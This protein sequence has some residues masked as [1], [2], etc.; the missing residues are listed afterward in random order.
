MP[1]TSP[2]TDAD[3]DQLEALL[4]DP[5]LDEAMRLDEI[6]GYLCG[7]FSGPSPIPA[8]QQLQEILGSDEAVASP[9]GQQLM[10]LLQRFAATQQAALDAGEAPLFLLYGEE[11]DAPEDY[12]AWCSAYLFAVDGSP[13]DWFEAIQAEEELDY[14]D[15]RLFPFM[16][17]TGEAEK[18]A[19][20][21]G[22]EWPSGEEKAELEQKAM[23]DLGEAVAEI[24]RFW[25]AK[26]G[27][28]TVR[29]DA[30][31]VGRNDPCPCGS[32]K[33]YK[34]CCGKLD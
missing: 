9:V 24:H 6:Q 31:K 15:E 19:L 5:S 2:L 7:A 34:Q 11:E 29:R 30:P 26:R 12:E 25:Q 22:E 17:L 14:L 13:E 8:E 18:A 10:P 23:D 21:H 4:D 20:E 27:G 1:T 32:G 33:K 16:I 28:E 3:L